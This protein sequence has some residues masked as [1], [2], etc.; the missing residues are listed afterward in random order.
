MCDCDFECKVE[1]DYGA[2]DGQPNP[3]DM[4][5]V[6]VPR[7]D[8]SLSDSQQQALEAR[9]EPLSNSDYSGIDLFIDVY[10][11]VRGL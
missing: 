1:A 8:V 4:G 9:Y 2:E 7:T 5:R 10:E 3:F 11:F 6:E